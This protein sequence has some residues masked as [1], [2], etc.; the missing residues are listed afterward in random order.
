[1]VRLT[2]GLGAVPV[3]LGHRDRDDRGQDEDRDDDPGERGAGHRAAFYSRA[4]RSTPA[5]AASRQSLVPLGASSVSGHDRELVEPPRRL[6]PRRGSV[7]ERP[8]DP[9]RTLLTALERPPQ[10]GDLA[11]RVEITR[12]ERR[13]QPLEPGRVPA[14]ADDQQTSAG[15]RAVDERPRRQ[16]EVD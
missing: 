8:E 14:E 7:E 15:V 1:L 6:E 11:S 10:G 4:E 12:R 9:K 2:R 16:Q 13:P 3:D 5:L